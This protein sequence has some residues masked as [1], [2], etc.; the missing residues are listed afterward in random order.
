MTQIYG[1]KLSYLHD[2]GE[3]TQD[4]FWFSVSDG[5]NDRFTVT[6]GNNQGQ[7]TVPQTQAQVHFP[8]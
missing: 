6:G 7:V 2:G 5:S 3:A 1:N 4:N 8:H